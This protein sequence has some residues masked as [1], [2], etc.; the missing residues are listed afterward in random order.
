MKLKGSRNALYVHNYASCRSN[1][2]EPRKEL[3]NKAFDVTRMIIL[4]EKN[5]HSTRSALNYFLLKK[6]NNESSALDSPIPLY[7]ISMSLARASPHFVAD[8]CLRTK[9]PTR[10]PSDPHHTALG[11]A[12]DLSVSV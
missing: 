8:A 10:N 4:C 2:K 5:E 7:T 3:L 6:I 1:S 9:M 11:L 12:R